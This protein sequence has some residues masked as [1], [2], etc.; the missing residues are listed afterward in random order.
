MGIREMNAAVFQNWGERGLSLPKAMDLTGG[1][2]KSKPY[3]VLFEAEALF[4]LAS[5]M[6][7]GS[8]HGTASPL[9]DHPFVRHRAISPPA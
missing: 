6:C 3:P 9:V 4:A 8:C 2:E 1:L 5:T 7:G